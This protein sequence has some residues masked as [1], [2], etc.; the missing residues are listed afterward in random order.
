M[1]TLDSKYL[2][3][4]QPD[5][6][7]GADV[8]RSR[9]F[10]KTCVVDGTT[11][12]G[13]TLAA[14]TVYA[15]AKIPA[16]FV[17]RGFAVKVYEK[18]DSATAPTLAIG[19]VKGATTANGALSGTATDVI[20][21]ASLGAVGTTY[22]DVDAAWLAGDADYLTVKASAAA[23]AKFEIAVVGDWLPFTL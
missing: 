14:G 5:A 1:A 17:P 7:T 15:A 16:G 12:D 9:L 6:F 11:N 4:G 3:V 21:S 13:D 23:D 8:V 10:K 19:Y 20:A 18:D 22:A 2:V